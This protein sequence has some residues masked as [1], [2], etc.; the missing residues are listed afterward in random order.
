MPVG[1]YNIL[2]FAGPVT[3]PARPEAVRGNDETLRSKFVAHQ[4][5][6]VAHVQSGDI[7]D[8]PATADEG[9]V[10]FGTDDGSMTIYTGGSWVSAVFID[11][12]D[13]TG[14]TLAPNVIY[15]S[16][17]TTGTLTGGAVPASLVTAGTFGTGDYMFDGALE[18]RTTDASN[19][20][21]SYD[22]DHYLDLSVSATGVAKFTVWGTGA[23]SFEIE[24]HVAITANDSPSSFGLILAR[25]ASDP[26]AQSFGASIQAS[27]SAGSGTATQVIGATLLARLIGAGTVTTLTGLSVGVSRSAG[28]VTTGY[29]LVVQ[30]IDTAMG[31]AYGISVGD[32]TGGGTNYALSTG[33]GQVKFGDI[34]SVG[35]ATPSSTTALVAPAGTT[36]VASL[37]VPHGV[38]PTSPVNG[39]IWTTTSGFL[40]RVNGATASFSGA[41]TGDQSLF[42]TVAVSGQ[43]N[44]VAD[45]TGDTLTLVAGSGMTLTTDAAADSVTFAV[46]SAPAG[47]LTGT[48]LA[49]GV[50]TSSLTTIGTLVSGAVPASLVTAGT[51]GAGA[52]KIDAGAAADALNI[53]STGTS[54]LVVGYSPSQSITMQVSSTGTMTFIGAGTDRKVVF[55]GGSFFKS[56]ATSIF[57]GASATG[58]ATL[59]L[60]HGTAPSSPVNGDIW[61]A[62]TGLY[63]YINAAT[64]GPFV[65]AADTSVTSGNIVSYSG[66]GG[67]AITELTGT[68]GDVLYH[69]GTSW[70]KLGAGTSGYYLQTSGAAA[71]P[72]WAAVAGGSAATQAQQETGSDTTTFVSPGRQQ[73]H[74]SAAKFWLEATANSTTILA[75]YNVASVDDTATGRMNI[76]ISTDFS[77]AS[78]AGSVT[79]HVDNANNAVLVPSIDVSTAQAA[80]TVMM[81]S[82]LTGATN[83]A[84]TDPTSWAAIGF[85]DQ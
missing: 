41:N 57:L 21:F 78:W 4:D 77:S 50:V 20:V 62:S 30:P 58:G 84:L 23:E 38:A 7:A 5:D 48:T 13:L 22:D 73:F 74:P 42:S 16:L 27:S 46:A 82:W 65:T 60:P 43:S 80:G 59:N 25:D 19:T 6:T 39:D 56:S 47:T 36:G 44:V 83:E 45:A 72:V 31:T 32:V 3:N 63:A 11:A 79:L 29:G 54:Q 76:N 12:G 53:F 55:P 18:I 75:S 49:A 17:T 81:E 40:A 34:V 10:W 28:T 52:Y 64:E 26:G 61:V 24:G 15:S 69:N 71:N 66:T 70:A 68:Q 8:R 51:F 14:D 9:T 67:K 1:D 35:G 85:G 33:L 2:P 37:R